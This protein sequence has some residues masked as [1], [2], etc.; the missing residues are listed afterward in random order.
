MGSEKNIE[1]VAEV[2]YNFGF[3]DQQELDM[4]SF[5]GIPGCADMYFVSQVE[6][7]ELTPQIRM[8]LITQLE[9]T[10]KALLERSNAPGA[11]GQIQGVAD[12]RQQ[13]FE[14]VY[15]LDDSSSESAE[16]HEEC[17]CP[18]QQHYLK[19]DLPTLE[20]AK[21]HCGHAYCKPCL[22]KF[23]ESAPLTAEDRVAVCHTYHNG[24]CTHEIN[25]EEA[26]KILNPKDFEAL[27]ARVL[28]KERSQRDV[29]K[30]MNSA[31]CPRPNCGCSTYN[32]DVCEAC[33]WK[34]D[35]PSGRQCPGCSGGTSKT[36][37]VRCTECERM[38]C[39][40]CKAAH[41][42]QTCEEYREGSGYQDLERWKQGNSNFTECTKCGN[43]VEKKQGCI[44]M[45]CKSIG[46][47]DGIGQMGCGHN[48]CFLCNG[49]FGADGHETHGW[50]RCVDT[51]YAT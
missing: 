36:R 3:R 42:G 40:E 23:I 15:G 43:A 38:F 46:E 45:E 49:E 34:G 27:S 35:T 18:I 51:E 10:K 13:A 29:V 22:G 5:W 21:L 39:A 32:P 6:Q 8:A 25:L 50:G 12:A 31:V 26:A 9:S 44:H 47:T 4:E 30:K 17:Q 1:A 33:G 37:E 7:E 24:K 2:I 11:A 28:A 41:D 19:T 14:M 48:W 16:P 20:T